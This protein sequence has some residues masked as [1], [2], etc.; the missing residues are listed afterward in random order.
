MMEYWEPLIERTPVDEL[1]KVQEEKLKKLVRYVYDHSPFYK[2]RFD[3]TGISPDDIQSLDDLKKLP[4]TIKKDLRDTYPDGMFCVP[5]KEVVRY[6]ASSGT[7]GKPTVVGY[8][9]N[10]IKEWSRS[11]ARGLTSIGVGRGDVVQVSY[12]Y[13]LFTGGLG[14]HY[15]TEMIGAS[16]IP[17]SSGNTERQI[18]LIQ[19]LGATT[20]ACTPSYFLHINEVAKKMGIDIASDTKLKFGIFGAEP[21][22]EEMRS[23]IEA[24]TGIKAYDIFGTSEISGPLFSECQYQDGI[25]IWADQFLIEVIDPETGEQLPDGELGELVV[26]TLVKEALPLIPVSYTHLTLPT[27]PY[28]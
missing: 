26:T 25:H 11:L 18:E 24:Q 27:T 16:A 22:S 9:E 19:D 20:I 28:V 23:R 13:G 2:K 7:T 10:D 8:T 4:F 17:A 21:W 3:E 1:K 6:H 12:G 14:F 5:Q 15:S